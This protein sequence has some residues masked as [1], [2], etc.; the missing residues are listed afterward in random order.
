MPTMMRDVVA[1]SKTPGALSELKASA[2][3]ASGGTIPFP[4]LLPTECQSD[5]GGVDESQVHPAIRSRIEQSPDREQIKEII[6][7]MRPDHLRPALPLATDDFIGTRASAE[8]IHALNQIKHQVQQDL[9]NRANSNPAWNGRHLQ[10]NT[11]TNKVEEYDYATHQ[12]FASVLVESVEFHGSPYT[13]ELTTRRGYMEA[14]SQQ[15]HGLEHGYLAARKST[16]VFAVRYSPNVEGISVVNT[17]G[18][19]RNYLQERAAEL[20]SN[21]MPPQQMVRMVNPPVANPW[22]LAIDGPDLEEIQ[23][24]QFTQQIVP[25]DIFL[26]SYRTDHRYDD[27]G[28]ETTFN[29]VYYPGNCGISRERDPYMRN[30]ANVIR[31]KMRENLRSAYINVKKSSTRQNLPMTALEANEIK[32][33]ETLRDMITETEWRRYATNGFIMVKAPSNLWYQIFRGD[34]FERIKVFKD[35]KVVETLCIHTDSTCPPTDHV[36]NMK[37]MIEH[38]EDAVRNGSNIRPVA[39]KTRAA[40]ATA[41]QQQ[42]DAQLGDFGL[43]VFGAYQNMA[44]ADGTPAGRRPLLEETLKKRSTETIADIYKRLKVG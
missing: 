22:R 11:V 12:R 41:D 15:V 35:N 43:A 4:V 32:A 1:L 17:L 7:R 2:P 36:I 34:S 29:F 9:L 28:F 6:Q 10:L 13:Y 31:E 38:D 3:H 5:W 20:L 40:P 37:I 24:E 27:G 18:S 42:Y 21:F 25:Q 14:R 30:P 44:R 23:T 33:R 16:C 26:E 39:Q 8:N 19:L